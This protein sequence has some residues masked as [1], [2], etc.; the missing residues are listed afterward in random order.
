M[1]EVIHD[2]KILFLETTIQIDRVIGGQ[3][4]RD[5]IR[6]NTHGQC[7][8]T[9][10][11]VLAEYNRTL[12]KDAITFRNLLLTSPDVDEA[13]KRFGKY[14]QNRK[15]PRLM[16]LLATLGFDKEKQNILDRLQ[17]FIDWQAYDLFWDSIDRARSIDEVGCAHSKWQ[18]KQGETGQYDTDGL[19]CLK[20]SP[21]ACGVTNFVEKNRSVLE[22]FVST[23]CS[24]SR[25]NVVKAAKL[26]DNIL[27]GRDVPFGIQNCYVISDTLIVLEAFSE[28]YVYSTD[29]D[30]HVICEIIGNRRYSEVFTGT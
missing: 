21:P 1:S 14:P 17:K 3:D 19:K 25:A 28:A 6:R 26:F 18:V 24:S 15:F 11:Y 29:G 5:I 22:K 23:G 20:A 12:I 7:L 13:I 9:S 16:F 30:I 8:C 27:N 4:Q 2:Q 10:G